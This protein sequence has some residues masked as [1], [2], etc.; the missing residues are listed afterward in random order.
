MKKIFHLIIIGTI[1]LSYASA[2]EHVKIID[3]TKN[4]KYLSQKI[5]KNYLFLYS[6]PK[7]TTL[8]LELTNDIKRLETDFRFIAK[9]SDDSDIK[10]ILDFLS[11]S[12]DQIKEILNKDISTDSIT[13]ILD[14]SETLS[15]GAESILMT[16]QYDY[17]SDKDIKTNLMEVSKFYLAQHLGINPISNTEQLQLKMKII[18]TKLKGANIDTKSSWEA[19]KNLL[20]AKEDYFIPNIIFILIK[21]MKD[22]QII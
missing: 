17:I 20:D 18:E 22:N 16:Y 6:N 21:N 14:Y 1:F 12:K 19:L 8:H 5:A 11:Y 7:L 10:D 3:A 9:N 2:N 4:I 15:E 13:Q